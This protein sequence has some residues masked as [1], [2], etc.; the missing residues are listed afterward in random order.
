MT[1]SKK[2]SFTLPGI[3][4]ALMFA[5]GPFMFAT[6]GGRGL[7]LYLTVLFVLSLLA[8][9]LIFDSRHALTFSIS[10]EASRVLGPFLI[11]L[12]WQ[13]L[14][15]LW[16][17]AFSFAS[18]YAYAKTVL[19]FLILSLPKYTKADKKLMLVAQT[20]IIV[21]ATVVLLTQEV[22]SSAGGMVSDRLTFSFFGVEQDPN[23]LALFYV[24]PFVSLLSVSLEKGR[25][26]V[27][28]LG[29][30]GLLAFMLFGL[31]NTGSRGALVGIGVTS[32]VFFAKTKKMRWWQF[33]LMILAAA[34]LIVVLLELL[35]L[36]LPESIADRFTIEAIL[37]SGGSGR[38]E[39]WEK[40]L[41]SIIKTP[42][43]LLFG[44][45]NSSCVPLNFSDAHNYILEAWFEYGLVG[46][47][48]LVFFY[49]VLF[50][51]ALRDKNDI[52]FTVII[53]ALTM[54]MFLSVGH[55]LPFWLCITL[56]NVLHMPE[57]ELPTRSKLKQKESEN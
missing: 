19:F 6:I 48:C 32:I 42:L 16:S 44:A 23:Y 21:V 14:T 22:T 5:C 2:Y 8:Q 49:F 34:A 18:I 46:I 50:R 25:H 53:G 11:C 45:G 30:L 29:A 26:V 31:L 10:T 27:L 51:T 55:M 28:R 54:A 1:D 15:F 36:I 37:E 35:G 47:V 17:P 41:K 33:L 24:A 4:A 9:A 52:S 43:Y 7:F 56:A 20:A 13:L 39:I 3:C 40:Y 57:K 12:F 38:T